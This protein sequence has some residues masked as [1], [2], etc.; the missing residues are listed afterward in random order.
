[1]PTAPADLNAPKLETINT[2]EDV[3]EAT[4]LR[5]ITRGLSIAATDAAIRDIGLVA[6]DP[7]KL[8]E[9]FPGGWIR[10]ALKK[11]LHIEK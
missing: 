5:A 3:I 7:S 4:R 6:T 10:D 2:L 1:M 11:V 9:L 8:A